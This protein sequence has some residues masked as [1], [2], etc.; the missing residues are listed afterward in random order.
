MIKKGTV[1]AKT[2]GILG[3]LGP[4]ASVYFYQLITEHTKAYGINAGN[5]YITTVS[6]KMAATA[7]ANAAVIKD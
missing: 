4:A 2:L 7:T 6:G 5:V 3:G 1:M